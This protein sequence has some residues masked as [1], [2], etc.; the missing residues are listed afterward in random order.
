MSLIDS[1]ISLDEFISVNNPLRE[2]N[3]MKKQIKF[4]KL[5]LNTLYR[6]CGNKQKSL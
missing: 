3:E 4:L 1:Y 6:Y 5:L 2:Y